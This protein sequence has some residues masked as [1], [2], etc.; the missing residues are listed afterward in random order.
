LTKRGF[1]KIMPVLWVFWVFWWLYCHWYLEVKVLRSTILSSTISW[2]EFCFGWE[3][4]WLAVVSPFGLLQSIQKIP[5]I[6]NKQIYGQI[7]SVLFLYCKIGGF[8]STPE[9][10]VYLFTKCQ[11]IPT[12]N[13]SL[14][15]VLNRL[16]V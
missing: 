9:S 10:I 1:V 12:P 15:V 8:L 11:I 5:Q 13:P 2:Q 4:C 6:R 16:W 14:F 7:Y 3:Y